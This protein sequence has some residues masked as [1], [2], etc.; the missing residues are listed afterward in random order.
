MKINVCS[1]EYSRIP[2]TFIVDSV[3]SINC[4][5]LRVYLISYKEGKILGVVCT[6]GRPTI[7]FTK[8]RRASLYIFHTQ[9]FFFVYCVLVLRDGTGYHSTSFQSPLFHS[10]SSSH[11]L[12]I[13]Q[14][15]CSSVAW[16]HIKT[17]IRDDISWLALKRRQDQ[18][19][20]LHSER[21]KSQSLF[22]Q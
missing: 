19:N 12:F 5:T 15:L 7:F 3:I 14:G 16:K 6:P 22:Q 13:Y 2:S 21:L 1:L 18:P 4:H 17:D 20:V 8:I 11:Q 9:L 10:C